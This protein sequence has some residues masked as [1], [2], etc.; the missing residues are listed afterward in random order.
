[1]SKKLWEASKARKINSNLY[2]YE[3]FLSKKYDSILVSDPELKFN[4][5]NIFIIFNS[6]F[7]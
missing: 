1:M 4:S 2:K 6:S 3:N 7:L 5:L